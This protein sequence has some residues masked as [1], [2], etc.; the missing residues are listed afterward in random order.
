MI[1]ALIKLNL[2]QE[3]KKLQHLYML[4]WSGFRYV[5]SRFTSKTFMVTAVLAKND[6]AIP[7]IR[8]LGLL[9]IDIYGIRGL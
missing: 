1:K 2:P 4:G 6:D 9:Y 8:R 3:A 7:T 5:E